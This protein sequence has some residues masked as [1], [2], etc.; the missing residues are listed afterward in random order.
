MSDNTPDEDGQAMI[1]LIQQVR[2]ARGKR[3]RHIRRVIRN[4][5]FRIRAGNDEYDK[6]L[7]SFLQKQ[8]TPDM[9]FDTF[10]FTWDVSPREPLK[11][12][13][14]YEWISEG[15]TFEIVNVQGDDGIIRQQKICDPT[16]F[17][18]QE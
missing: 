11:V 10:T 12:I 15:G 8:L 13:S 17:T 1:E 14:P 3:L 4:R 6:G 18:K 2:K 16:A 7:K 9:S 5:I